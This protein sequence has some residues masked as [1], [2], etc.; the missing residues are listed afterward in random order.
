MK[1]IQFG[2]QLQEKEVDFFWRCSKI[3]KTAI[4]TFRTDDETPAFFVMML[5][6]VPDESLTEGRRI[7]VLFREERQFP[8]S[9]YMG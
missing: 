3:M 4:L 1:H 8:T 2:V 6:V 5:H 7:G 9:D